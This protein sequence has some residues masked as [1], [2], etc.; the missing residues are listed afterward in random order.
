MYMGRYIGKD[1]N[2]FF[3][4]E[5]REKKNADM[6]FVATYLRKMKL[7]RKSQVHSC[8]FNLI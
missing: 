8:N 3:L 2:L 7:A 5:Q 4:F 1:D 6:C